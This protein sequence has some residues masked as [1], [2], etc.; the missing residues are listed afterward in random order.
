MGEQKLVWTGKGLQ[1][2]GHPTYGNQLLIGGDL[3]GPGAKP[4]DLLPLSLAACTCYDVVEILRK[5][6]QQL[7]ELEVTTTTTQ[8]PD[9]P[10]RFRTIH[11]HFKLSGELDR[12]KTE[13]AIA[14]SES[15]YCAVAATLRDAVDLSYSV[16]F[17]E[18]EPRT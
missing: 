18:S 8:D 7:R 3:E 11:M 4:A 1:F 17:V 12:G 16:E 15:K 13:R 2:V 14:L 5:Q 9:P 10:W 6:R